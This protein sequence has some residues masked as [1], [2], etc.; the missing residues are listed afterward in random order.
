MAGSTRFARLPTWWVRLDK[1]QLFS[2]GRCTGASI[3]GLKCLLALSLTLEFHTLVSEASISKI[4]I[5]TGLSR[6][7]IIKGLKCLEEFKLIEITRGVYSNTYKVLELHGKDSGWAK[8]PY[9]SVSRDLKYLP[10]RGG[11]AL[12]TL[13][14]YVVILAVRL[15]T[16]NSTALS[17]DQIVSYTHGQRSEIRRALDILV[18]HRLIRCEKMD[19]MNSKNIYTIIGIDAKSYSAA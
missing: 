1:L 5:L 11:V 10:N 16:S 19:D 14:V 12:M 4:E 3:A 15:N 8:V 6:P 18:M 17:Y 2:A 13:K 7:M 9:S